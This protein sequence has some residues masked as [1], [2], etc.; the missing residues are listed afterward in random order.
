MLSDVPESVV[1]LNSRPSLLMKERQV[2][3]F[4]L[5]DTLLNQSAS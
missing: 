4:N 3:V 5:K 2:N 1:E